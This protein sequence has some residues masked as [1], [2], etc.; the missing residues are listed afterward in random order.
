MLVRNYRVR[1]H[2]VAD[3][4]PLG[5]EKPTL[6]ELSPAYYGI[7]AAD[8]QRRVTTSH[9]RCGDQRL[10]E[11]IACMEEVYCRSIGAQFMHIDDLEIREWLQE[12]MEGS[13]NRIDLSHK[14]QL[15]ILRWLTDAVVFE[16]F[17]QKRFLG[18]KSFSLEGAESLLP[19]LELAFERAIEQG[20]IGIVLGMSHRGRLNVL[21]NVIGKNPREIFREFE[22]RDPRRSIGAG[23]VKYHLGYSSTRPTHRDSDEDLYL[24]LCFNPSHLEFISPVAM[25]RVRARQERFAD[26]DRRHGMLIL[27]HGDAAFVGEGVVQETLNLSR[28]RPYDVGGTLHVIVNNQIG[29]T[30]PPE[31]GRSSTYASDVARM[32]QS[33]VFHVNGEDPEAVAQVIRLATDFRYRFQR[34]VVVDMYCYRRRG[35]NETDEPSFTQP[36]MARAIERREPLRDRYLRHLM[37]LGEVSQAEADRIRDRSEQRLERALA[38]AEK[39]PVAKRRR[40]KKP[41]IWTDYTG[42]G[43]ENAEAVDTGVPAATLRELLDAQTRVPEGFTPHPK[44]RRA[45]KRRKAMVEGKRPL[46][47]SAAEALALASIAADGFRVRLAGQ[48]SERGTFSH[49]HAVLHD[50]ETGDL[51]MPLQHVT[52]DQAPVH[53]CNAAQ[54]IIDQF[55]ASGEDKWSRLSGLV[56]LLPHGFEG[57]GPEHSSARMERFLVL[58][59]EDNIQ[60]AVPTTPAQYFHLLRQQMLRKWRKPLVVFTPKSLLRHPRAVSSWEELERGAFRSAIGDKT[61]GGGVERVLLCAGKIY[62]ELIE[63]REKRERG[64]VGVAR[65]ELL[66]PLAEDDLRTVLDACGDGTPVTWV[67]EEPENMGAWRTLLA[68]FG[69]SI[70]G[71]PFDGV[72]RPASA[73]PA[74]GS[75][76][77]HHLEQELLLDQAFGEAG[78]D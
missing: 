69:D 32:L 55:I 17:V 48:D 3:L 54:V 33:P 6:P 30:T 45:V 25:G 68:R 65:L 61:S 22:D 70:V 75:K 78:R 13:R 74:T 2:M 71:H 72:T 56:L 5:S 29:F 15:R 23:D 59:A 10:G 64:D 52:P 43:V 38:A 31:E 60:I 18:A 67:Q 53:F 1:G 63:E 12:R 66:Y 26:R 51:W 41:L 4:D 20:V 9:L 42:G 7:T 28:L 62:Y 34:D 58:A 37:G 14:Q 50:V 39:K 27:I 11:V 77:S 40:R 19:L 21:A 35:H 47:W 44:I 46:D 73:S 76:A 36:L 8:M 49:R 57:M 16:E 24:S